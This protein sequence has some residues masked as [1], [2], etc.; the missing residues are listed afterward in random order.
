L[1]A[2]AELLEVLAT[3]AVSYS[4]LHPEP[5]T[6]SLLT[7][8]GGYSLA[9]RLRSY[10]YATSII[11]TR[12]DT[13]LEAGFAEIDDRPGGSA[14]LAESGA[15]MAGAPL[16]L[17]PASPLIDLLGQEKP[18]RTADEVGSAAALWIVDWRESRAST[19]F[20]LLV[21]FRG[22]HGSSE[23]IDTGLESILESLRELG[24]DGNTVIAIALESGAPSAELR[25]LI[26]PPYSWRPPI[27]REIV[28]SPVWG[29]ELSRALLNIALSD[30][31]EPLRLPGLDHELSPPKLH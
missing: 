24:L 28:T 12:R 25:A 27:R 16:L 6:I 5:E 29:R 7:L 15:W 4:R 26:V 23:T 30:G 20:E 17:G 13:G 2:T 18:F 1:G 31:A 22:Q 3:T 14:L 8:P 10:G 9:S 11:S 21:D 19:P